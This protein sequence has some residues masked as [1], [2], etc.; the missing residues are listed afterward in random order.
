MS[1]NFELLR[2]AG[3]KQD[4]FEGAQ[5]EAPQAPR[6]PSRKVNSPVNPPPRARY[7][8]SSM[9]AKGDRISSLVHKIFLDPRNPHIRSAAFFGVAPR[10]GCTWACAQTA[11]TLASLVDGTVCVV[12]ANFSA[13]SLHGQFSVDNLVGFSDAIFQGKP[14]RTLVRQIDGSNLHIICAGAE[15]ARAQ[16]EVARV[17]ER[18]RELRREFDY[19]L[20]DAPSVLDGSLAASV[21]QAGDG[22]IL[23]VE[24]T[25]I[26]LES[27]LKAKQ[28][29]K[30]AHVPLFGVVLNDRRAPAHSL[31]G[32]FFK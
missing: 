14:A 10:A 21:G 15:C 24:S 2:Q 31:I 30:A 26:A 32:Q 13:P 3:W 1:K 25:G 4:F 23:V 7:R 27:L 11:R 28:R 5:T 29:L 20:V 22:A 19:L 18:L 6:S 17:G 12:D 9:P 8:A 16:P